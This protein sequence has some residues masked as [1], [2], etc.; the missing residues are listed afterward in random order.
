MGFIWKRHCKF[1]AKYLS[2]RSHLLKM[3][4]YPSTS[5]PQ[6]LLF[7]LRSFP[8]VSR[9]NWKRKQF[10]VL[11]KLCQNNFKTVNSIPSALKPK[12]KKKKN[13]RNKQTRHRNFLNYFFPNQTE[14]SEM[15]FRC[16]LQTPRIS[17]AWR[18]CLKSSL[19]DAPP[20]T[21]FLQ[22][23]F[24][25]FSTSKKFR[26]NFS[27]CVLIFLSIV[28]SEWQDSNINDS[29]F[30]VQFLPSPPPK[31]IKLISNSL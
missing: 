21:S 28:N 30:C 9:Q 31:Q 24:Y 25:H 23:I 5:L 4:H 10:F 12:K 3:T 6:P 20:R 2:K 13:H 18:C 1:S 29:N 17:P 16:S 26:S 8:N 15:C 27:L 7:S 19:A 22:I 11:E 14:R